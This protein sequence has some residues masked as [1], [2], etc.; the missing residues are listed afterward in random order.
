MSYLKKALPLLDRLHGSYQHVNRKLHYDQYICCLLIYFFNPILTSLRGLQ[1]ATELKKVQKAL[2]IKA[3]SR[4][5]LSEASAVFDPARLEPLL[6]HLAQ[7]ARPVETDPVLKKLEE[8]LVA[9][10]GTILP[11]LPKMLWALWLDEEHRAA[12]LH[13]SF[14]IMKHVPL[15]ARVTEANA[16]ERTVFRESLAPG[17]FYVLDAG[18]GEYKLFREI[19]E[20]GSSFLVRLRKDAAWS[21]L[22]ANELSDQDRAAGVIRD[23]VVRIGGPDR[24]K[25]CPRPIRVIEI[26]YYPAQSSS[27]SGISGKKTFRTPQTSRRIL[28]ASNRL[29]LPAESLALLYRYRWQV[30]LFFRWFKCVLSCRHMLAHSKNGLTLQVY[31]ALIVSLLISLWTGKKPTKRT[32]E[33]IAFYFLN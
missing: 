33:M 1:Q 12:K 16:G 11:A 26:E 25:D 14:S 29:D 24:R 10:D 9:V 22:Q 13:L 6:T 7:Q 17:H 4:S 8:T 20:T 2:G 21:T 28:L 27:R 31:A 32:F 23:E 18:Y 3:T 19:D 15:Q 30:E 5:C